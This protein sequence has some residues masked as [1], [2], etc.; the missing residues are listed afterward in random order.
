MGYWKNDKRDGYGKEL[1]HEGNYE[2]EYKEG[3]K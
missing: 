2:G 3:I 1:W